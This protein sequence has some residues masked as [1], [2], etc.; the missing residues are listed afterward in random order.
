[1]HVP[2]RHAFEPLLLLLGDLFFFVCALFVTLTVRYLELPTQDLFLMHVSP[3]LFLFIFSI[4]VYFIA[5]LYD[6]QLV[7]VQQYLPQRVF[8]AQLVTVIGGA[9][10]FFLIPIFGIAPKTNLLIYLLLSWLFVLFWRL[11]LFPRITTARY[12]YAVVI[13]EG[14]E[15]DELVAELNTNVRSRIRVRLALTP[16]QLLDPE[17]QQQILAL[18][19]AGRVTRCVVDMYDQNFKELIPFFYVML[20]SDGRVRYIDV[21]H[22]YEQI[23]DRIPLSELRRGWFVHTLPQRENILYAFTKR[24]FDIIGAFFFGI[25]LLVLTPLV[26]LAMRLWDRGP[27]FIAQQRIGYRGVPMTVYK[28]RTMAINET[29]SDKWIGESQN[30]ITR[31]GAFLRRFSIDEF[32]QVWNIFKGEL[33]FIGPRNDMVG[34]GSRLAEAIP[35]YNTRYVVKPG[36]S[37]WAQI[38]Q[39]Y[40][41]GNV[42]PQSIEETRIRLAYDLYYIKYRSLILDGVIALKTLRRMFFR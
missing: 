35:Y 18:I 13:A 5:G 16:A 7:I 39:H 34:L 24:C 33:S 32:P 29:A 37:G 25:I 1:M 19:D 15:I 27:L 10:F 9:L 28:F 4:T 3:F 21:W 2:I 22:M 31:V 11:V 26:Y 6:K 20:F 36:I 12:E 40:A 41:P 30:S 14:E 8:R 38:N 17:K 42:S 23:F